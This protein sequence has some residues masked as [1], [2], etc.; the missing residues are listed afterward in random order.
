MQRQKYMGEIQQPK[1][2]SVMYERRKIFA[3]AGA[4][5]LMLKG[6]AI[7]AAAEEKQTDQISLMCL[8]DSI[9]DGF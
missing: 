5:M 7:P 3:A 6:T 8:G 1:R 4:A 9:T 2:S